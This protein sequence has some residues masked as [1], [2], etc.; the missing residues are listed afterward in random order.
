MSFTSEIKAELCRLP[1][2][3]ECCALAELYGALLYGAIFSNKKVKFQADASFVRKRVQ[4]LAEKMM[5]VQITEP[6]THPHSLILENQEE[7]AKIYAKFGYE[8]CADTL[9]L[10]RAV[11]DDDCC[12]WAFAR[13]TFLAGGSAKGSGKGYHLEL[14]CAHYNIAR[15]F[16]ILLAEMGAKCGFVERRGNFVI[17]YKDSTAIEEIIT[18]I[19]APRAAMKIMLKKV[20]K[21][22]INNINR[23]VNCETANITKT[24]DAAAKQ[25]EAIKVLERRGELKTL[26]KSLQET[27]RIRMEHPE[28]SLAE[29]ID[30]FEE[31]ISKP[32]LNNRMRK[33]IKLSEKA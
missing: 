11:V 9:H 4:V 6:E 8:F 2:T 23:K 27:A 12:R 32:G 1:H 19:G 30:F 22:F 14:A 24:V 21:E 18:S 20:E 31:P 28:S 25:A 17:Y 5:S 33:L 7:I 10:N 26:A 29:L 15:E 3:K 16:E 13:G